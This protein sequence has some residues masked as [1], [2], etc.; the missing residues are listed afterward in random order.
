MEKRKEEL[1]REKLTRMTVYEKAYWDIGDLLIA[2]LDEAG[3]GPLA[4]PVVAAC[5]IMPPHDLILGVDDSKKLSEKRR[6][7][8]YTQIM[9]RALDVSVCAVEEI[10]IDSINILQA[11]KKAFE[12][13]LT[14]LS[15]RPNH[16]YTDAISISTELPYTPLVS[17]DAKVYTIAAA[18]I[19]AKVTR[20]RIMM[21]YDRIYPQYGF[22]RH[23]GYGTKE[24]FAAIKQYGILPI[25]R[26]TF[27]RKL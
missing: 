4:G 26:K 17:G 20:D 11:T 27:L 19:V 7:S 25:H 13:A 24:H 21:E 18:S 2:G 15:M 5:V 6:E 23:K 12:T 14:G 9:E 22:A 16:V 3:R 10:E 8:L 1:L